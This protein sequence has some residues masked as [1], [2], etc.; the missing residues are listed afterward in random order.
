MAGYR[1]PSATACWEALS[2]RFPS[3]RIALFRTRSSAGTCDDGH[4][5]GIWCYLAAAE[6]LSERSADESQALSAW[7]GQERLPALGGGPVERTPTAQL[8]RSE[9]V[10]ASCESPVLANFCDLV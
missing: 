4:T 8:S 9:R 1:I 6:V 7:S 3:P 5:E 10:A 2:G